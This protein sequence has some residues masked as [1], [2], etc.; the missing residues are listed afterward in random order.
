M[1]GTRGSLDDVMI[2]DECAV[3]LDEKAS[4]L[5]GIGFDGDDGRGHALHDR[6]PRQRLGGGR[7]IDGK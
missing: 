3:C 5:P 7:P 2:G 6:R 1:D 4:A